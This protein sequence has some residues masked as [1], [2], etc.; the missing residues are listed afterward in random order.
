MPTKRLR[1][2]GLIT[3]QAN[4]VRVHD[5][6]RLRR[7]QSL[8]PPICNCTPRFQFSHRIMP[9]IRHEGSDVF[10]CADQCSLTSRAQEQLTRTAINVDNVHIVS[11]QITFDRIGV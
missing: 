8:T 9:K 2:D 3:F 1:E 10:L 6:E 11:C 4:E 5:W 7:L